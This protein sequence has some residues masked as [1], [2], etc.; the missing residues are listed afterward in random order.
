MTFQLCSFV[1]IEVAG[2]Y[3]TCAEKGFTPVVLL[4][5]V[6]G[7]VAETVQW[8]WMSGTVFLEE[9]VL[10]GEVRGQQYYGLY[11]HRQPE[12]ASQWKVCCGFVYGGLFV[13]PFIK[14]IVMDC[15]AYT[16]F[17]TFENL[18]FAEATCIHLSSV[19]QRKGVG[20]CLVKFKKWM[21]L[22]WV[23]MK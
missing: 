17:S 11:A 3:S 16:C 19:G 9:V 12:M 22:C 10:W 13:P 15:T 4:W 7:L 23:S 21:I 8:F 2:S 6:F 1:A 14:M 20:K 5:G 18:D